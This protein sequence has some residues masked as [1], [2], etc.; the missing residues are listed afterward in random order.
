[1]YIEVERSRIGKTPVKKE[2]QEG[3]A[4]IRVYDGAVVKTMWYW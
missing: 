2:E 4:D 1:M 3:I